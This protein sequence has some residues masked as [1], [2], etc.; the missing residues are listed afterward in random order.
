[1]NDVA[2]DFENDARR[3]AELFFACDL[4]DS[5]PRIQQMTLKSIRVSL[6]SGP[7]GSGKTSTNSK[8]WQKLPGKKILLS[9]SH[10]YLSE[11][12]RLRRQSGIDV[13]HLWGLK[14]RCPCL[15]EEYF[16]NMISELVRLKL[17]P[18]FVCSICKTVNAYPQELC[19]YKEQFIDMP[20]T[21]LAPIEYVFTNLLKNYKPDF[22]TVD[23]CTLKMVEH[24]TKDKLEFFLRQLQKTNYYL[25]KREKQI[26][27]LPQLFSLNETD[28]INLIRRL[29]FTHN[30]FLNTRIREIKEFDYNFKEIMFVTMS[31]LDFEIYRKQSMAFGYREQFAT[32]ALFPIFDYVAARKYDD[33]EEPQLKIIDAIIN[34]EIFKGIQTR[35]QRQ[36]KVYVDFRPDDFQPKIVDHDSVVHRVFRRC[37]AWYPSGSIKDNISSQ[38]RIQGMIG[39]ILRQRH[40]GGEGL[41]IGLVFPRLE[42]DDKNRLNWWKHFVPKELNVEPEWLTFANLRGKN[43]LEDCDVLFVVSTFNTDHE[44]LIEDFK[45]FFAEDPASVEYWKNSPHGGYYRFKDRKLD[46]FRW[47]HEE[48]EM[49]QAIHRIRPLLAKKV[50][51]V[52]AVVPEELRNDGL[53]VKKLYVGAD[54]LNEKIEEWII[55]Y[56]KERKAVLVRNTMW[57]VKY[58]L[59][60]CPKT[61]Y[62]MIN[63]AVKNSKHLQKGKYQNRDWLKYFD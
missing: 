9:H 51:Y 12:E 6:R 43:S 55:N 19:P 20:N 5:G 28:Y 26:K 56:V 3:K 58:K 42:K 16:N 47:A 46:A 11:Q 44:A 63:R 37:N 48:Y 61:A 27:Y 14:W 50:V 32:P 29:Y 21:V 40:N 60:I 52:I 23:D 33:D 1:V 30:N 2:D 22:I 59:N 24:P 45:L 8:E 17:S 57:A 10:N 13:R 18:R 15:K 41:K 34:D 7:P 31:P 62:K 4:P 35:Y 36:E 38:L 54:G 53:P 49:Y 25:S 39:Q